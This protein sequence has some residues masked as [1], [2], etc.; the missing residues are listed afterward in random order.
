VRRNAWLWGEQTTLTGRPTPCICSARAREKGKRPRRRSSSSFCIFEE[1]EEE[2]LREGFDRKGDC[3]EDN[4]KAYCQ[5][6]GSETSFVTCPS[7]VPLLA[8][9]FSDPLYLPP[10]ADE[11]R[12]VQ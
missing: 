12:N 8:P 9:S 5:N 3:L 4:L 11:G 2:Q 7:H 10:N 6:L 1:K